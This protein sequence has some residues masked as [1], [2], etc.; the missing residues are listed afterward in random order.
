M[1]NMTILGLCNLLA[2]GLWTA[3]NSLGA[4]GAQSPQ[5]VNAANAA[6]F[7]L[8]VCSLRPD[9]NIGYAPYAAGLYL[10]NRYGVEWLVLPGAVLC[11]ISAGLFWAV[12][13]AIAIAYPEPWNKGRALGWWLTFRLLGQVLGGAINLGLNADRNEAGKVSYAVYLVFITLQALGLVVSFFLTPPGK[14]ERRDGVKVSLAIMAKPWREMKATAE[15]FFRPQFL[16]I[17]L[18]I[19]QAVFAEAVMFTYLALWFSVRARALGSFLGGVIGIIAGNA[20]GAWLDTTRLS[21]KTRGRYAF[22]FFTLVS[23]AWWIWATVLVSRF[24]VTQPTYDWASPG[25]GRAFVVYFM[26]SHIA[27]G[28]S[29]VLRFAAFLQGTESAWQVAF[30]VYPAWLVVRGFG[31]TAAKGRQLDHEAAQESASDKIDIKG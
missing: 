23:G 16:L 9:I 24:R 25:F 17:L 8:M 1:Y 21:V 11:G 31:A 12:E 5:L 2:P 7:C 22:W 27:N 26:V 4:R 3:M 15:N 28:E 30:S 13:A 29:E 6:T 18:W 10:N 19:G 20:A 14:V